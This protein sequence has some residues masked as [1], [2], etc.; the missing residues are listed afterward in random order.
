MTK[1]RGVEWLEE[2]TGQRLD[3]EAP[4]AEGRHLS[5]RIPTRLYDELERL[6]TERSE[7]V[8]QTARRLLTDGIAHVNDPDR[9]AIDTAIAALEK[10]RRST[11]PSA[12]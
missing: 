6:A 1:P 3:R 4:G 8:S 7:T 9:E 2:Q 12:A 5:L 11:D 10:L